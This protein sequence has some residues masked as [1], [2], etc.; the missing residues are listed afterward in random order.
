M[1]GVIDEG[2]GRFQLGSM[3]SPHSNHQLHANFSRLGSLALTK[4]LVLSRF[5]RLT[6]CF[7]DFQVIG[8]LYRALNYKRNGY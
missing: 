5:V 3:G 7:I 6:E 8:S 1:V 2:V 4:S